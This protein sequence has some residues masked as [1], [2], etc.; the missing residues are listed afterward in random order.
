[1]GALL[2]FTMCYTTCCT[3]RLHKDSFLL[4]VFLFRDGI[5]R[6]SLYP[7][8]CVQIDQSSTTIRSRLGW[9]LSPSCI[10]HSRNS[11]KSTR[12]VG[13]NST[14]GSPKLKQ[15]MLQQIASNP[16]HTG[17]RYTFKSMT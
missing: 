6:C 7:H 2:L 15:G 11:K 1:M 9:R 3:A 4:S 17:Y 16:R 14:N 8:I 12:V 13:I 10:P 5:R